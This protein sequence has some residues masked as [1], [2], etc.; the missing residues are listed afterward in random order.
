MFATETNADLVTNEA[1]TAM[2]QRRA[3]LGRWGEPKEIG[4]TAVFLASSAASYVTGQVITVDAG[5][6]SH[7]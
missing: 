1:I 6:V 4:G 7:I 3:S 5:Y 2:L